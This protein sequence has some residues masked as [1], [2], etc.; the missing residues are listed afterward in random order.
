MDALQQDAQE[1]AIRAEN[2][3]AQIAVAQG[4]VADAQA[5]AGWVLIANPAIWQPAD[6]AAR[7]DA[8][9]G[10]GDLV[11]SLEHSIADIKAR[12]HH[13]LGGLIQ[14]AKDSREDKE[15]EEKLRSAQDELSLRYRAV[16]D[17]LEPPTGVSD[18]DQL[19]IEAKQA[20]VQVRDL[21]LTQAAVST[22][23]TRLSDEIKRRKD[24][25][26]KVGF[27]ALGLEA[28]L[29]FNGIRPIETSLVLKPK[30]IAAVE[31]PATLCRFK[32]KTEFV[33]GSHGVSIPLGH[34][35]RYRVSS[36]RGHPVQSEYLAHLDTGKLVVTNTRLVFLGTKREVSVPIAKLLQI[37]PYSDALGIAR[38]G[39]ETK[40]VYLVPNPAYV[41]QIL[42]WVI[43]QQDQGQA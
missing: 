27:D 26:S 11:L 33:G 2:L 40:D 31:V 9:R 32:T 19:L 14:G 35:F 34:G 36:F 1:L 28:E 7:L 38:E 8:A 23:V 17:G 24:V 4:Q 12:S 43:S 5:K 13:G 10:Q 21:T 30:E 29:K 39:K 42:Q 16:V 41:L 3:I 22:E 15:L 6:R 18:A 20:D 25:A 37:E